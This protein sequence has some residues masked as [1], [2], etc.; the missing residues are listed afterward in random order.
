M[1]NQARF[2]QRTGTILSSLQRGLIEGIV[3]IFR[4]DLVTLMLGS[5][6]V[7]GTNLMLALGHPAQEQKQASAR[8]QRLFD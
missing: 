4:G 6:E 7:G 3:R 2:Y 8:S 1:V 5:T